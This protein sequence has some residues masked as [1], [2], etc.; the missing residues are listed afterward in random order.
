MN[1]IGAAFSSPSS[2]EIHFYGQP[3]SYL[4][5]VF[6]SPKHHLF[7]HPKT[8]EM[9]T[10][11]IQKPLV[12][13]LIS[14]AFAFVF[15]Y[16]FWEEKLALNYVLFGL[17]AGGTTLALNPGAFGRTPVRLTAGGTLLIGLFVL[18]HASV[19]ARLG[20]LLSYLAFLGFVYAPGMRSLPAA[21]WGSLGD[22]FRG[23]FQGMDKL[24]Q[25]RIEP[26]GKSRTWLRRLSLMVIPLVLVVLFILLFSWANQN[27]SELFTGIFD[28]IGEQI[29]NWAKLT[30]FERVFML[31]FGFVVSG[32]I[33]FRIRSRALEYRDATAPE[34]L[35][36]RRFRKKRHFKLLALRREYAV[37]VLA[38]I[39]VN[40]VTL[41]LNGLDL[42][43]LW[44][45]YDPQDNPNLTHFVHE[46]TYILI[47]SILLAMGIMFY[48]F[49]GN[50]NFFSRNR[51]LRRL[52]YC[53]IGQ[54]LF[55]VSSVALRNLHYIGGQGLAYKRIGVFFFLAL[56]AFGL[57]TLYFKIR[58]RKTLYHV[59]RVNAWATYAVLIL[60]TCF[61]WDVHIA[62]YNLQ[63]TD[64]YLDRAFLLG[65]SDKT[66]P[67]LWEHREVFDCECLYWENGCSRCSSGIYMSDYLKERAMNFRDKMED[68]TWLSWNLGDAQAMSYFEKNSKA[69]HANR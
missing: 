65:L 3:C 7:H 68:R 4:G 10:T 63:H 67:I 42:Y 60:L 24:A 36:R 64:D 30:S 58:R 11:A 45:F 41:L 66:L 52:S 62:K 27:F 2:H 14:G 39:S 8:F 25:V 47:A 21:L 12:R 53:W 29:W 57:V 32:L 44:L 31:G 34:T 9:N 1:S 35:L 22:G 6:G 69:L 13:L 38:V 20:F 23:I 37:A 55:M 16:F 59:V 19:I 61:N 33:F 5:P 56:T 48:Y 28:W 15:S 40:L 18:I 46:G 43:H 54:N 26:K 17:L 50:L 49:R 51:L